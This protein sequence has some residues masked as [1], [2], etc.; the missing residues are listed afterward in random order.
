MYPKVGIGIIVIN[1]GKKIL[2]GKRKNAHG[3]GSWGIPGGNLEFGETVR[4]CASR[5]LLEETGLIAEVVVEGPWKE[6]F[7]I[8]ENKHYLNIFTIVP[9][10][11]GTVQNKELEKTEN[12]EWFDAHIL[13]SPLFEPIKKIVKDNSLIHFLER[14]LFE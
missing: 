4:N 7:F 13:P 5:E 1:E 11:S 12:W 3:D 8:Q 9:Q 14:H 10:F 6:I 2:L